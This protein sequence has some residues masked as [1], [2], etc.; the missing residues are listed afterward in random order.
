[1]APGGGF[2]TAKPGMNATT[3]AHYIDSADQLAEFLGGLDEH[4]VI[5]IDTEFI[6]ERT[7]YPQLCLL[8]IAVGDSIWCVDTLAIDDLSPLF[9]AL[10]RPSR[11]KIFHA[12]RQDLEIFFNETRCIP[13]PLFDTQIAAALLGRP[14]QIAYA[15]LVSEFYAL[16]LDKTS[17]RTNWAQRP[18]TE[19]QLEY[20]AADVR[21]LG[22]I[23]QRLEAEI[24]HRGRETWL[25]EECTRLGNLGLYE[26]DPDNAW[27][28]GKGVGKLET[29]QLGIAVSLAAWRETSARARNLPRGWVLK[30][31]RLVALSRAAPSSKAELLSIGGLASGLVRRHGAEL[32]DTINTAQTNAAYADEVRLPRLTDSGKSLLQELL[33]AL[34]RCAEENEVSAAL[35]ATRRDVEMAICARTEIR[36]Y[37]GWRNDLFGDFVRDEVAG[38][39]RSRLYE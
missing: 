36:L 3:G 14:D 5:A 21:Y 6:R 31:D 30:D 16:D 15:H 33:G 23:K 25:R 17:S 32:L 8:Q 24:Q 2:D 29:N 39:G 10:N 1:M 7:Y 28:R 38:R 20:A 11:L 13:A 19:R 9:D 4:A 22:G 35:I 18:L 26:N 27:R 34:R 12:A 37:D